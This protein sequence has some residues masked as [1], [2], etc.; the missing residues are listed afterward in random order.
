MIPSAST[1]HLSMQSEMTIWFRSI[2]TEFPNCWCNS[3]FDQKSLQ[4]S[5]SVEKLNLMT[6]QY[7]SKVF[8][9]LFTFIFVW[10]LVRDKIGR[11]FWHAFSCW[12]NVIFLR[13]AICSLHHSKS[14]VLNMQISAHSLRSNCMSQ[15]EIIFLSSDLID[16]CANVHLYSGSVE[17]WFVFHW[18]FD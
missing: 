17:S 9:F 8:V 5:T 10:Y 3:L 16:A 12:I 6:I 4:L 11:F 2:S 7:W 13:L 1:M 18:P 15:S 14:S